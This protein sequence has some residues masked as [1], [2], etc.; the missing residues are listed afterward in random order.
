MVVPSIA[1]PL[2]STVVKELVPLALPVTSPYIILASGILRS[3]FT[4]NSSEPLVILP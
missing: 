1:P 2:I 3:A 4:F